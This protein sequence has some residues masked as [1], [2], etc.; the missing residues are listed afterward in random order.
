MKASDKAKNGSVAGHISLL[1]AILQRSNSP[2]LIFPVL[3]IFNENSQNNLPDFRNA[4]K[5]AVDVRD[6]R[7]CT[8]SY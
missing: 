5:S 6:L 2:F 8:K 4:Q 1:S 7:L 3:K